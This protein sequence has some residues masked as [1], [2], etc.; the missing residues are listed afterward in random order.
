[1]T[2]PKIVLC[3]PGQWKDR[4]D[5]VTSIAEKSGGWLFAGAVLMEVATGQHY[6][7]EIYDHDP[8]L[9][10]AFA[11]ANY[12]RRDLSEEDFRAIESHSFALYL[13]GDGG[14]FAAA[15]K[16]MEAACAL[17]KSGGTAIK[18]E[19]AGLSHSAANWETLAKAE[20][21]A[22]LYYAFVALVADES[23]VYSCGMH[24]LGLPDA[25]VATT[26]HATDLPELLKTFLLYQL[27]ERPT[28]LAGQTFSVDREAPRYYLAFEECSKYDADDL[29]LN[30]YGMWRLTEIV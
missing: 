8:N 17:L 9:K 23:S 19:S 20:S 28:L 4:T 24:L 29:F 25:G 15:R 30:P 6:R 14:S 22:A 16:T 11:M 12:S 2:T 27:V 7:L 1:M 13:I 3:I 18:V 5:I 10:H 26:P 21:D